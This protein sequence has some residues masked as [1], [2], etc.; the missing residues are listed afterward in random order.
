MSK[1]PT[2]LFYEVH[3]QACIQFIMH[4]LIDLCNEIVIVN[5]NWK[6]HKF[7]SVRTI[8]YFMQHDWFS[9]FFSSYFLVNI[10]FLKFYSKLKK[11]KTKQKRE[12]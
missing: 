8:T 1:A 3:K 5:G 12:H 7:P 10:N 9:F 4:N 11:S 6:Q 2:P